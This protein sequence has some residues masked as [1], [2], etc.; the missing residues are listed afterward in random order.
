MSAYLNPSDECILIE[1]FFDQYEPNVTLNGG[2]PVYV[3]LRLQK[4]KA[5]TSQT[6]RI[7]SRDWKL[8]IS[9]LKS[10][11]TM[12]TKAIIVNTPHNPVRQV[13]QPFL[14]NQINLDLQTC[15]SLQFPLF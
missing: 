3:P 2:T 7:S 10:K 9:E 13:L 1:P 4:H 15:L 12:K 14:R 8:D 5:S 6:Y 11:I